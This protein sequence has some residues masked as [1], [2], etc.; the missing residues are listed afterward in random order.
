MHLNPVSA[1]IKSLRF[2]H[3]LTQQELAKLAG[4]PRATVAN[5]ESKEA[6][7]TI[8][9]VLKIAKALGVPVEDLVKREGASSFS[10]VKPEHMQ[11]SNQD[12][13]RY[14]ATSLAPIDAPGIRINEVQM[15]PGCETKGK[16]HPKGSHEFFYCLQGQATLLVQQEVVKLN[17]GELIH[18][19]GHVPHQ[20]CNLTKKAVKAISVVSLLGIKKSK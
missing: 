9:S 19:L 11:V 20:Y 7:P 4:L 5:M 14:L 8:T 15:A 18:F 2:Q 13:G 17:A 10:V 6:N 1:A 3:N 12:E 16:P